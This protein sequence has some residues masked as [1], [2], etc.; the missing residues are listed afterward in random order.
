MCDRRRAKKKAGLFGALLSAV[1]TFVLNDG[2]VDP[3]RA[4]AAE[5]SV[6]SFYRGRTITLGVPSTPGAAYDTYAKLVTKY[7]SKYVP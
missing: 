7:F 1:I 3:A 5:Q 2:G 4:N 6:A